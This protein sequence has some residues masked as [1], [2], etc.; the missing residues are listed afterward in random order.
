MRRVTVELE[1]V[2]GGYGRRWCNERRER[3][4]TGKKMPDPPGDPVYSIAYCQVT[5]IVPVAPV[6]AVTLNDFFPGFGP[7][8]VQVAV[9]AVRQP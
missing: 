5:C 8:T 6:D 7:M 2:V 9:V 3:C 4:T 1:P